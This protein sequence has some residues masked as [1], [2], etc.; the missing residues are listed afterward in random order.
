M[1]TSTSLDANLRETMRTARGFRRFRD[2]EVDDEVLRRCLE[3][4]TWAPSGGNQ[5]P[6]RFVVLRSPAARAAIA[7]G[8]RSALATIQDVYRMERPDPAD[9]S[10]H[11]RS[12]RAVFDLHDRAADVPAAVLFTLRPQPAV[13][14][15]FQ[16]AS[17]YPAM[18]N[19]LL[20]ARAE[21]LGALVTGWHTSS[22]EVPLRAAVGVPDD[23]LLAALVVV[24][25]PRGRQGAVRRRPVADVAALDRWDRP[26]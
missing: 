19:F 18:Q 20:A 5:Q 4:A 11:A 2:A 9:D 23:W 16:G 7:E 22:G 12:A 3:A 6:W 8:A 26:F 13:P 17:I 10:P 25:W 21:G 24:G 15:L 14:P 1:G